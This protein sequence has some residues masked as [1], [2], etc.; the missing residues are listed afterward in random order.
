MH[1]LI[2]DD[3][4]GTRLIASSAV[5]VLG[6]V[7][8]VTHGGADAWRLFQQVAPDAVITNGDMPG[9]DGT[10]LTRRIRSQ[11]AVPYPY[12]IVLTARA[13]EDAALRAMQAGADDLMTK[14]LRPEE[15]ERKLVAAQRVTSLHRQLHGDAR[16]DVLTGLANRRR[17]EEDLRAIQDRTRR[18]GHTWC[19]VMIDVDDF[20]AFNDTLGHGQG[21]DALRVVAA[22]LG[23]TIRTGDS[24]YRLGGEEFLLLLP[25]QTRESASLAAERLRA[26]V[27][28]LDVPHPAG[29]RL[30]VSLGVA[31]PT[32]GGTRLEALIGAADQALHAARTAG[33]NRVEVVG[34]EDDSAD[35]VRVVRVMLAD[36]DELIRKLL[37][38]IADNE[39]TV[40]LVGT[41][42][43]AKEAIELAVRT[44]PD[45]VVLDLDMPAGG[46]VH[47]ATQIRRRLPHTRI[48]G[49]SA[50]DSPA[51]M[52][53][54]GRAGAVG[55]IVKGA[56]PARSSA[57]SRASS[58]TR[59]F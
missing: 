42:G 37:S 46:G 41:A 13:D 15:L 44:R 53:D 56:G 25:G 9:F 58:A 52:L 6:H 20:K 27:E 1:I 57:R 32:V 26:V 18:Y 38:T 2:A 59:A 29:G 16:E 24:L 4:P 36:D 54:M 40:E 48:V 19:A 45:V 8:T 47:A 14:P 28:A 12:V 35:R 21:D 11:R 7:C 10:E 33:P 55:F 22:A 51:A 3:D 31:G 5:E 34:A 17:L 50:D 30:T 43:D 39:P 23:R 49:L